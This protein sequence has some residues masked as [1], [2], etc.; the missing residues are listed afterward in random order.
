MTKGGEPYKNNLE[1]V[2]PRQGFFGRATIS[3]ER[4]SKNRHQKGG[5]MRAFS[6]IMKFVLTTVL[7]C[8]I[9]GTGCNKVLPNRFVTIKEAYPTSESVQPPSQVSSDTFKKAV[10]EAPYEDVFRF[11]QVAASQ[12]Q[13]NIEGTDKANGVILAT[14]V[15]KTFTPD[16]ERESRYHYGIIVKETGPKTTEVTISTKKQ[17]SCSKLHEGTA[18]FLTC[19]SFGLLAP[20]AIV[21]A[22]KCTEEKASLQWTTDS[23]PEINQFLTLIRNNLIAAGLI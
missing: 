4:I 14:R 23:L 16:G 12:A 9:F 17:T 15:A 19:I 11:A 20:L 21:D 13:L 22:V 8:L 6:P 3:Q 7:A 1:G 5:N 2:I 18:G 10:F